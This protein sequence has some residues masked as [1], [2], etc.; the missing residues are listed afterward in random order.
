VIN[1]ALQLLEPK[2][3]ILDVGCGTGDPVSHMLAQAGHDVTGTDISQK[4][5][6]IA[7]RQVEGTL[8]KTDMT[9]YEPGKQFNAIFAIFSLFNICRRFSLRLALRL[10]S[11]FQSSF[12]PLIQQPTRRAPSIV[13]SLRREPTTPLLSPTIL[14]N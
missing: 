11:R 8:V 4:M 6:D 5:L 7:S 14:R 10:R 1:K 9:K 2:A 12:A 13:I 3:S